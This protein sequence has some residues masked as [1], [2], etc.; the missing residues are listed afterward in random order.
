[1]NFVYKK[2][3]K[4]CST[5]N[6][7]GII[8]V[9]AREVYQ[10]SKEFLVLKHDIESNVPKAFKLA[11]IEN[12]YGHR[13][14]YY[15]QVYL[16]NNIKNVK[17]LLK[18][19]EMGHEISYHHDVMDKNHGNI[20]MALY[21]FE[22]NIKKFQ[23]LG[24]C[25][26]TVCQHGNPVIE[27]IGYSSNRDFFRSEETQKKYPDLSDIMVDY[28]RKRKINY[29]YYSDAGRVFKFIYDPINND[30]VDSDRNNI[31]FEDLDHLLNVIILND[32]T[33]ISIHPHRWSQ[34]K[35]SNVFNFILFVIIKKMAKI[36][37]RIPVF[38]KL[39]SKYYFLAKK[40]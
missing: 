5:L 39:M 8:S 14:S 23:S 13:G 40:I 9:P 27:R 22:K 1:M 28:K 38:K 30:I 25:I 17:L 18:M 35:I 4:F 21:D 37:I 10:G 15:A 26:D 12:K 32:R 16:L 29:N 36:L 31:M 6:I 20:K 34:T 7:R 11:K 24:F 2:W 3:D 19:Q 33:I